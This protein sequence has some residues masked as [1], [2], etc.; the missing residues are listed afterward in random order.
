MPK[1]HAKEIP[2]P[3]KLEEVTV[4]SPA[5]KETP[6][7]IPE[8]V[9]AVVVAPEPSPEPKVAIDTVNIYF[10]GSTPPALGALQPQDTPRSMGQRSIWP[11][12]AAGMGLA[13]VALG[14]IA[15]AWYFWATLGSSLANVPVRATFVFPSGVTNFQPFESTLVL[16][17]VST[18]TLAPILKPRW[19]SS[20]ELLESD[21]TLNE[22][23][24]LLP[25]LEPQEELSISLRGI[26]TG[27]ATTH[28]FLLR[29]FED[30]DG[31]HIPLGE[32]AQIGRAHV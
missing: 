19:P 25:P 26:I 3:P 8:V 10:P 7:V 20:F 13:V 32:V 29:I 31:Q 14:A 16:K 1:N 11:L 30:S 4:E 18:N 21:I 5:S 2:P 17:N 15:G 27:H 22:G 24:W 23:M 12:V 9:P 28:T 6:A